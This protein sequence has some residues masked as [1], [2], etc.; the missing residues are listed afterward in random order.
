MKTIRKE[1]Q[2]EPFCSRAFSLYTAGAEIAVFDIETTGLYPKRDS[3]ILSGILRLRTGGK[4]T[5]TQY[6]S[7]RSGDE[8]EVIRATVRDLAECDLIV[9]YNGRSF[10]LPFLRTRAAR[11]GIDTG[12]LNMADLDLYMVLHYH[13]DLK[14]AI[15]SLA[16]KNVERF[17]GLDTGRKDEIS[18]YDSVRLYQRYM[19]NHD[20]ELEAKI[21]LHNHD[22]ILQLGKLLP[23]IEK[24]D[25][26]RAMFSLGFGASDFTVRELRAG[27]GGL[28]LRAG[29]RKNAV[30]YILFP[31]PEQPYS[32]MMSRESGILEV[33][34]PAVKAAPGIPVIDA[35]RILGEAS[36]KTLEKYPAFESGYL[37]L[38]KADRIN[39]LEINA[40]VSA[41]LRQIGPRLSR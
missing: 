40:F 13:S 27:D 34:F 6:F 8:P 31:T 12:A 1:V 5:A 35:R 22:D 19:T 26:H 20:P 3:L 16:Q 7:D 28:D 25:F 10:D 41:F 24:T 21:L 30:D 18:G 15:G 38:K 11:Y 37:I 32:L 17:M 29:K 36:M 9:T 14:A 2:T 39:Y 23:V 33:N 4:A